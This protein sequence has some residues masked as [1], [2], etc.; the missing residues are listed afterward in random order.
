MTLLSITIKEVILDHKGRRR[1]FIWSLL[2][3]NS[4]C[5]LEFEREQI[6][7]FSKSLKRNCR[8]WQ[9]WTHIGLIKEIIIKL[10]G[11]AM[12]MFSKNNVNTTI[13]KSSK[14]CAQKIIWYLQLCFNYPTLRSRI[15]YVNL[16]RIRLIT[17]FKS[18]TIFSSI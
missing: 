2:T 17:I 7:S 16:V 5:T 1:D 3:F 10:G 15:C 13:R 18:R 11:Q 6:V 4:C 14:H 8:I 9:I 12:P